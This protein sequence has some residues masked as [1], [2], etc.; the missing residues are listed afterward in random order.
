[1]TAMSHSGLAGFSPFVRKEFREWWGRR[2]ALVTA[3]VVGGL[4]IV[5]TLATRIDEF[6]GGIPEAGMLEPT[7]N[8]IGSKL[9]EWILFAAIFASI[10]MLIQERT[11]GTLAWTLSKPISRTSL[12][13]AKW[14]SGVTMLTVF[15]IAVPLALSAAVATVAYGAVPDIGAVVRFGVVLAGIPAFFL[16]LNLALATRLDNQAGIAAVA[17]GV[18]GLPYIVGGFVPAF[19]EVWPTAIGSMAVLVAAGESPNLPT[20]V[21]WGVGVLVPI[22]LG[23]AFFARE[24]L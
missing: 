18:I 8:V 12:L 14:A 10:G 22:A 20:I 4:T 17:F 15:G 19:A 16:A 11:T 9:N 3:A 5:G 7:V 1:M 24:D 21:G 23:L 13:L 6:A 2:A